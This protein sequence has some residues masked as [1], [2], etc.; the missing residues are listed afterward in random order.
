MANGV[1]NVEESLKAAIA[2]DDE[3]TSKASS[4]ATTETV[5][6]E[7]GDNS[8]DQRVPLARLNEV[9]EERNALREEVKTRSER[10]ADYLS[11]IQERDDLLNRIRALAADEKYSEHVFAIDKALKGIED[12]EEELEEVAEDDSS[13]DDNKRARPDVD[14]KRLLQEQRGQ[15]EEAM[16]EQRAEALWNLAQERAAKYLDALPEDFSAQEKEII[17]ELWNTRVDW[18]A[19]EEDSSALNP[20]LAR[21]FEE[22]LKFYGESRAVAK[23]SSETQTET[24]QTPEPTKEE[25]LQTLLSTDFSG[26][27]DAGKP[28]VSDDEF[29]ANLASAIRMTR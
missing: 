21:S 26:V 4:P 14:V 19:I 3:D 9:I 10:D 7:S 29:A 27:D 12:L 5:T 28:E 24:A 15:L 18:D 1:T 22:T 8:S 13:S 11:Q 23:P 16:A 6:K 17:A 20:E 25:R 2:A